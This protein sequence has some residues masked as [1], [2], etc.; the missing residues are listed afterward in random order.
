MLAL[1]LSALLAGQAARRVVEPLNRLD[2]EHPL[3]NNVYEE[4]SINSRGMSRVFCDLRS[5]KTPR[6]ILPVD[7]N[8][9]ICLTNLLFTID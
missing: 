2:L 6:G 3:D 8:K 7:S 4:L 5:Q 9:I 1:G